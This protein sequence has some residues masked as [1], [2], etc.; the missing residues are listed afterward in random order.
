M[1]VLFYSMDH[2]GL[3]QNKERKKKEIS[4]RIGT[5]FSSRQRCYIYSRIYITSLPPGA[6]VALK[7]SW[8]DAIQLTNDEFPY[9]SKFQVLTDMSVKHL[10]TE[11]EVTDKITFS[12]V[13]AVHGLRLPGRLS[14]GSV[15]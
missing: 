3:I 4:K 10:L 5:L 12:A 7:R 2:R 13:Q 8:D 11:H 15:S 6:W 14:T 9:A 1:C